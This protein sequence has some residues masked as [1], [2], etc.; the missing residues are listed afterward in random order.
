[1]H[2]GRDDRPRVEVDRVL[3][4]VGKMGAAVLQ[5]GDPRLRVARRSPL[6]VG[7]P[8]ALPLAVEPDQVLGRGRRDP[9]LLREALQHLAV[10]LAAVAA[11]DRPQGGVGLHGRGVDADPVAL[12]QAVLGQAL[13]HPGEDRLVHLQ[14]QTRARPAQPGVVGHRLSGAEPQELA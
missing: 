8:L 6:G 2:L 7:Q 4:L 11:H 12:D 3:R 10:A 14:R 1:M 5:L 9:A 13:Q